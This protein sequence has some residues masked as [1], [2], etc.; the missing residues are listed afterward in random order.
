MV[1]RLFAYAGS[2][3][4]SRV[5]IALPVAVGGLPEGGLVVEGF[6]VSFTEHA[7]DIGTHS[8]HDGG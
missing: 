1:K 6:L 4:K 2:V 5:A 8:G 3:V 7:L